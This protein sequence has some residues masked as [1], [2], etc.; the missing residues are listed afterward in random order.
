MTHIIDAERVRR[1]QAA[2]LHDAMP[3]TPAIEID[4]YGL[5]RNGHDF[6]MLKTQPHPLGH[7]LHLA[8]N[9]K[10]GWLWPVDEQGMF[11]PTMNQEDLDHWI[12]LLTRAREI[13]AG[14]G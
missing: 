7:T 14:G 1:L 13:M 5:S 6:T 4:T 2:A 10:A 11:G 9:L 8:V 3:E 12:A